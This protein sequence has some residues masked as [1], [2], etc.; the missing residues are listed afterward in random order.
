MKVKRFHILIL[1]LAVSAPFAF[2]YLGGSAPNSTDFTR[3]ESIYASSPDNHMHGMGYDSTNDRLYIATHYGLFMLKENKELYKV[4][5]STDDFMGF[6]LNQKQSNMIYSSGHSRTGG[7]LGVLRSDDGGL[8]WRKIFS[9]INSGNVDFH[10]M[11]I[12]YAD[13]Q[14]LMGSF[15]GRIYVTEDRGNNWRLA[16]SSPPQGPCWGAPCLS[17]D[18]QNRQRFYAG[19]LEGLYVTDN[20]GDAWRRL[21]DGAFAGVVMHPRDNSILFAFTEDGIIKSEDGGSTWD[22]KTSGIVISG[23]EYVFQF[24]FDMDNSDTLYAAT[25]GQKVFKT[26]NGGERWER[27]L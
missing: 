20:L 1:V 22:P 10:S 2:L 8:I 12:S 5:S 15:G 26:E 4:G 17:A 23:N 6:S 19:T 24:S 13:P 16:V 11:T 9:N 18:T 3:V 21:A 27:I 7:N 25:T 14:V